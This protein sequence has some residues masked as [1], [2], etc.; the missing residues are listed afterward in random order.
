[1]QKCS[2]CNTPIE[3]NV[4][5]YSMREHKKPL[6]RLCQQDLKKPSYYKKPLSTPETLKLGKLLSEM[7]H[8][9]QYEKYDGYKHIDIAIVD[10]KVNIEVDGSHHNFNK[11][12]ALRDLKRTFYSYEKSFITLRIPNSLTR[13]DNIIKETAKYIDQFLKVGRTPELEKEIIQEYEE[14]ENPIW[15]DPKNFINGV[16]NL[17]NNVSS[18]MSDVKSS[19]VNFKNSFTF[20]KKK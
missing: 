18:A 3:E 16:N 14:E 8:N 4:Y 17:V 2:K 9:V 13:D 19:V 7:G 10:K 5:N 1:M 6:C 15:K 12:Q 20:N 11:L